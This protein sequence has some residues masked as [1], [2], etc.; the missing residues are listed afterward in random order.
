MGIFPKP[1][2]TGWTPSG[3]NL[4][5]IQMCIKTFQCWFIEHGIAKCIAKCC[6]LDPLVK[7]IMRFKVHTTQH[8]SY[9]LISM[10]TLCIPI[11]GLG[12]IRCIIMLTFWD[13]KF[14]IIHHQ[15][16]CI[17]L[18]FSNAQI[19]WSSQVQVEHLYYLDKVRESN[20]KTEGSE[21]Q[22]DWRKNLW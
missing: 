19:P 3:P 8:I 13:I 7:K 10:H 11:Y 18:N 4:A 1:F 14:S 5:L 17:A 16:L 6:P 21:L 12:T 9:L 22:R 2:K 20:F 15:V